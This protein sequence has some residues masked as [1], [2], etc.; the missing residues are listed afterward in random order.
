MKRIMTRSLIVWIVTFAFLGGLIFLG[1]RIVLHNDEWVQQPFNGHMAASGG[2]AKAGRIYDRNGML[3]AHSENDT[4]LYH[5]NASTREALLHVVGDNSLNISTAIQSRYRTSLT[6]Y[7]FILGLGLPESLRPNSDVKL[8]VDADAC[9]AAYEALGGR[10]GAC[11]VYN[12]KTGEVLC[13]VSA[14]GYDPQYPPDIT[15]ENESE[16][17]GVYLDNV[18]SSTFTPGSTFKIITAAAAVENI[19]DIYSQTFSC[20]G[21]VEIGGNTITCESA[22][23]DQSF[24]EAFANSCNCA[25]AQIAVQVGGEKMQATAERMGFNNK[26]LRMSDIPL[27]T[28]HYDAKKADENSLAWSGIGQH[29][30]L[31]NPMLM[32]MICSAVANNGSAV[33]PYIVEDDG[34]LLDKLGI[35]INKMQN[36]EMMS[37]DT[38]ARLHELMKASAEGYSWRGVS[39]AGLDFCA[40]TGTAEVGEDKEPTA[41]FV[42]FTE[43]EKHPYAFAA[44]VLEGGYGI[45]AATPVVNAAVS[46]LVNGW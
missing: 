30:D 31:A 40:K 45:D 32:A 4:R 39:V 6:G 9:R 8:T 5:D 7:S 3:L 42:G 11:V 10:K 37:A 1:V 17:D 28:S 34:K 19:P 36:T 43:D 41:W 25:F 14:P 29:E 44:V 2:L 26:E 27:A 18:V 21:S 20:P 24:S 16:Y 33:S 38:A 15:E 13:D 22:H 35:T 12:Y 46:K 23:G